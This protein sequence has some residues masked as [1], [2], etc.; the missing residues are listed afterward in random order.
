M[1]SWWAETGRP[2]GAGAR[3][4]RVL[5]ACDRTGANA[6]V[7]TAG[8]GH[9]TPVPDRHVG[10]GLDPVADLAFQVGSAPRIRWLAVFAVLA[11]QV[12]AKK[13]PERPR[14]T[15]HRDTVGRQ[16]GDQPGGNLVK[17]LRLPRQQPV[18]VSALGHPLAGRTR[19]RQ[20]V[21]FND[22]HPPV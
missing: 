13:E 17:D 1:I 8:A 4:P 5:F 12:A 15:Q 6:L 10:Q 21:P 22:R 18:G 11:Q 9:L 14:M 19:F 20:L 3:A 7:A 16:V 2:S